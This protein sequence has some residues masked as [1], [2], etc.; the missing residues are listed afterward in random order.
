MIQYG[1]NMVDKI[2]I[3]IKWRLHEVKNKPIY[4]VKII[5][6]HLATPTDPNPDPGPQ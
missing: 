1:R 3:I 4:T 5:L 6:K 2:T